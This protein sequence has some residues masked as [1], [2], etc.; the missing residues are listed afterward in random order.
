MSE[1]NSNTIVGVDIGG[2]HISACLVNAKNYSIIKNSYREYTIDAKQSAFKILNDWSN[3]I[4]DTILNIPK[5]CVKSIG[6]A[7]P[8]PFDYKNGVS[9]MFG[10]GK[11]EQLLGINIKQYFSNRLNLKIDCIHFINDAAAFALGEYHQKYNSNYKKILALTLGTG[12]GSTY[13]HDGVPQS[14]MLYNIPFK[15]SIANNYFSTPWFANTYNN[16]YSERIE[17]VK[18]LFDLAES[19]NKNAMAIFEEFG[20]NLAYFMKNHLSPEMAECC[21]IGGNISKAWKFFAPALNNNLSRYLET[22]IIQAD[23]DSQSSIIG[24]AISTINQ[25][26][27]KSNNRKTTQF[28]IPEKVRQT[29]SGNYDIYPGFKVPENS[30]KTGYSKLA[31]YIEKHK[32]IVIDGYVGVNWDD[33]RKNLSLQLYSKGLKV[34]WYDVSAGIKDVSEIDKLIAPFLGG[35]DPIFGTRTSLK[36]EDYFKLE[37]LNEIKADNDADINILY[38]SGAALVK[39]DA[40][41]LYVDIPKNELQFRMRAGAISNLGAEKAIDAKKMYKRFYFVDWV[42]LNKHKQKLL[43][44]ID[45]IIDDQR[46]EQPFWTTGDCL[47]NSLNKMSKSFFRVRPWFEPGPWGG[48]WMINNIEQLNIDVPNYAWS[49]E[50]IVPENGLLLNDNGKM[51]EISF[52]FLMFQEYRNVLG[53]AAGRFGNEFPIRFD[54]LD[55][56][57][58]GNLSVQVHP[59]QDYF[60]KE[61]GEKFTQD[62]CYYILDAKNDAKVYLGFDENVNPE[63]LRTELDYSFKNSTEVDIDKYVNSIK[64]NKHDLFLIP[65]GTIHGSGKDNLVLEISS[66]PYIFTFKLYDWLR[67]DLEGKPRPLNIERGFK[68]LDFNRKGDVINKEHISIPAVIKRGEDWK[69]IHLP[70]HKEHFYDVHRYEFH[71]IIEVQTN[72]QCHILMLVEGSSLILETENGMKQRFNFAETF[73]VPAACGTYKLINEN[74]T[75]C[76]VVKAFV[77]SE[78][79]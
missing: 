71:T 43:P 45:I 1:R 8:G 5:G 38:G 70:T 40:P 47:R 28:L 31:D 27:V 62:E 68:N 29:Q 24:A 30:I 79:V 21:I 75:L 33:L 78:K 22:P 11:Y 20:N 16:K 56:F 37:Y 15:E 7:I 26:K 67:L 54:F 74:N 25:T 35:D 57:D 61:F 66:T 39:W 34:L 44:K 48:T 55:T 76:K 6:I 46:P 53:E 50:L 49:F 65:G 10:V 41:L 36:F 18:Q 64:A 72:N 9:K 17:N 73:V 51:L 4:N 52:D 69:L 32:T 12:F 3:L 63:K 58:G 2:T 14:K 42:L 23:T 19:G 13:V 77:K 59:Q 60:V